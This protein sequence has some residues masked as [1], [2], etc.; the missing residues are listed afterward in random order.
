MTESYP[1]HC[2]ADFITI[3]TNATHGS[4][5]VTMQAPVS[6]KDCRENGLFSGAF[7]SSICIWLFLC[8]FATE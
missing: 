4:R 5:P 8:F 6:S 2:E 3:P 1:V 7:V